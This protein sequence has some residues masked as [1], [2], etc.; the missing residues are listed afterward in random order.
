MCSVV[1]DCLAETYDIQIEFRFFT[2]L[3]TISEKTATKS[4]D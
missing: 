3:W 2:E 4:K 1:V